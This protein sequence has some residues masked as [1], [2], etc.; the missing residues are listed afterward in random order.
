MGFQYKNI[1]VNNSLT[2]NQYVIDLEEVH[3][4]TVT[5]LCQVD[6]SLTENFIICSS[7]FGSTVSVVIEI[8]TIPTAITY[9]KIGVSDCHAKY[10]LKFLVWK[11]G[12]RGCA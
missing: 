3:L 4:A 9:C 6:V 12:E 2:I 7:A 11:I 1:H 5:M 8:F 10:P